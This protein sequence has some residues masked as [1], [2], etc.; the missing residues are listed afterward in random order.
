M[1]PASEGWERFH[2][3]S[4][5]FTAG[6]LTVVAAA[7]GLQ[8]LPDLGVGALRWLVVGALAFAA[9]SGLY[10]RAAWRR[11]GYRFSDDRL[12]VRRGVV[13]KQ[14]GNLPLRRIESVDVAEK[15]LPRL[16]GLAEVVVEV[17]SQ[18]GSEA[19]L[20]YLGRA[21]AEALAERI[22]R[23]RRVADD[24]SLGAPGAADEP[25]TPVPL[26]SVADRDLFVAYGAAPVG[27][28]VL[29]VVVL[30]AVGLSSGLAAALAASFVGLL[31]L[32][33]AAIAQLRRIDRLHGFALGRTA[34]ELHIERGFVEKRR[35][36]IPLHRIQAVRVE[37][38]WLWRRFG[39]AR[40]LVT[41]AGYQGSDA[42]RLASSAVLMPIAP[43]AE[44]ERLV[45]LLGGPPWREQEPVA[46]APAS[47]RWLDPIR[48]RATSVARAAPF[49][50]VHTGRIRRRRDF[51]TDDKLQ[52]IRV[53]QGPAQR[54]LGL[55]TLHLDT[56]GAG[57]TVAA[58]NLARV[59]AL[60]QLGAPRDGFTTAADQFS[61]LR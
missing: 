28:L 30:V 8:Q 14:T 10:A 57:A 11:S 61:A 25:E 27:V 38:P 20:R 51:V 16:F 53:T 13:F 60:A 18:G 55:S 15:A 47:A 52:S 56:A 37:E 5:L 23:L 19:Q 49:T 42:E 4:P 59:D 58:P 50:I 31:A 6:R 39:R 34:D 46:R 43:S 17:A 2:P 32:V 54:S 7:F 33:S 44:I 36:R 48:W 3:L 21:E 29:V 40:L 24:A 26:A 35:Q 9:A 22:D 12:E 41:V 1:L 45:A